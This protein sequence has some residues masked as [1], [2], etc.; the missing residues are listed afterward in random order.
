MRLYA[1][2]SFKKFRLA[3]WGRDRVITVVSVLLW[4][5]N[6]GVSAWSELKKIILGFDFDL[7]VLV[8][9]GSTEVSILGDLRWRKTRN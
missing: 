4:L 5:T 7:M 1:D 8:C 2:V 6:M 9:V 3:L